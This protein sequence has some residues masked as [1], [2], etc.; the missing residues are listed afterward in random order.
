MQVE[1]KKAQPKEVVQAANTAALLGKRVILSNLGV[2]PAL[3]LLPQGAALAAA[4][5][6]NPAAATAAALPAQVP[7]AYQ[8]LQQSV[9]QLKSRNRGMTLDSSHHYLFML[10]YLH[11]LKV[12]TPSKYHIHFQSES[13]YSKDYL[14]VRSNVTLGHLLKRCFTSRQSSNASIKINLLNTPYCG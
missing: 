11:I 1:C 9:G 13:T 12:E 6:G 4:A 8:Q 2:M 10:S 14:S 5:A 7:T 3:S